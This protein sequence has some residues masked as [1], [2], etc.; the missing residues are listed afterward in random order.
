MRGSSM[1][2]AHGFQLEGDLGER[3]HVVEEQRQRQLGH[4]VVEVLPQLR[5]A[6]RQIVRRRD[7]DA[8][9][10][11]VRREPG[12]VHRLDERRVGDADEHRHAPADLA[13][14]ALD[15]FAPQPVAEAGA[16]A[17]RAEDEQPADAAGED[18]LDEPFEAG[19]VEFVTARAWA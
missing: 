4:Q 10:P 19:D 6:A 12:E 9:A 14:D 1:A 8:P 18:V 3:R 17:R 5:L 2:R 13:A 7:H 15:Q 11:G 16:F